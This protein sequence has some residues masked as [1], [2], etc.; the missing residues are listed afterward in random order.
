MLVKVATERYISITPYDINGIACIR[1]IIF[2]W[3]TSLPLH[4]YYMVVSGT[5][6]IL[7]PSPDWFNDL[8]GCVY[9]SFGHCPST[10]CCNRGVI[11][12]RQC[13][14]QK[15]IF[16]DITKWYIHSFEFNF[17]TVCIYICIEIKYTNVWRANLYDFNCGLSYTGVF[18]QGSDLSR[19][20][21]EHKLVAI[22]WTADR[23]HI[24][25]KTWVVMKA[26]LNT[27]KFRSEPYPIGVDPSGFTNMVYL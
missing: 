25:W 16:Q 21:A 14:H 3:N 9:I 17:F 27:K 7:N 11:I 5:I 20:I 1:Y 23:L 19:S 15:L 2:L 13:V 6:F 26:N 8:T 22:K 12:L 10:Q 24:H 18:P 4:R